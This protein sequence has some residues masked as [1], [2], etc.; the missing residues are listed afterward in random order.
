MINND[1]VCLAPPRTHD[2]SHS[3]SHVPSIE[4]VV[5]DINDAVKAV[6]PRRHDIRYSKAHVLLLSW[7]ENDL[8]GVDDE[9]IEL[10]RAFE[11]YRYKV[12]Q[13]KI[14]SAKPTRDIQRRMEEF[15]EFDGKD[16]LLVVYYGGHARSGEHSSEGSIWFA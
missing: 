9:I 6:W 14:P 8:L 16:T 7:E 10:R 1:F 13:H 3:S 11:L 12:W 15:L 4:H 5:N 2:I